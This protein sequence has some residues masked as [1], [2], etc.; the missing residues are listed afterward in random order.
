[1][2]NNQVIVRGIFGDD[3]KLSHETHGEKFYKATIRVARDSGNID[4]IPVLISEKLNIREVKECAAEIKGELRS[5]NKDVNGKSKLVLS[6]FAKEVQELRLED[7][8]NEIILNCF[9]VKQPKLR[10]TPLGR[11]I[12]DILVAVNRKTNRSDYIPCVVWGKNAE[13]ISN[14]EIGTNIIIEGRIQSRDYNKDGEIKTTY[15]V[16]V[17]KIYR[18]PEEI[19]L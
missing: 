10:T 17:N 11:T 15:E 18:K 16:S 5:Y 2:E 4:I 3:Y 1:M 12:C 6:L 7:Y 14:F 19:E 8:K 13:E 9:I